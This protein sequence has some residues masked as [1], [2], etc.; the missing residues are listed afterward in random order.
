[1]CGR[2]ASLAIVLL[3]PPAGAGS[4]QQEMEIR[5]DNSLAGRESYLSMGNYRDER[6]GSNDPSF[7]SNGISFVVRS[8]VGV[9]P[10]FRQAP[11]GRN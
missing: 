4:Q 3:T 2:A 11:K 8:F 7:I 1:M 10:F 9:R 6:T 5:T